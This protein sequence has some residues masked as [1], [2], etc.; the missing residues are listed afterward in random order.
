MCSIESVTTS[1]CCHLYFRLCE[2]AT[3]P[4]TRHGERDKDPSPQTEGNSDAQEVEA[5]CETRTGWEEIVLSK[6][7][8]LVC[9]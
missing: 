6:K 1:V 5:D 8:V 3:G 7:F 2:E 4:E 9:F